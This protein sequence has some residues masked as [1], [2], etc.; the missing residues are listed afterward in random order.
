[1]LTQIAE[2]AR[3]MIRHRNTPVPPYIDVPGC[4]CLHMGHSAVGLLFMLMDDTQSQSHKRVGM[5]CNAC[6]FANIPN[7]L[8]TVGFADIEWHLSLCLLTFATWAARV[9]A[10]RVRL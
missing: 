7:N 2:I 3:K 6:F 1:M 5:R 8:S 9:R 4:F 10:A